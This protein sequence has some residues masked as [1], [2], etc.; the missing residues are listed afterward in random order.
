MKIPLTQGKFA[1]VDECDYEFLM[2]WTWCY[3]KGYAVRC[4]SNPARTIHMHR[5]I[6]ERMGFR[7]FAECDHANQDKLDNC[8]HNLRPA[9]RCQNQRNKNKL[10]NNTS[11]YIGVYWNKQQS[12]WMAYIRI[13]GKL[14]HLGY[15]DDKEDAA[16][17][18]DMAAIVHHGEFAQLNFPCSDYLIEFDQNLEPIA[19]K[20][21]T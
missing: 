21:R 8:R 13:D 3:H 6:L 16:R 17:A 18:R 11:G 19:V 12:K 14:K 15:F 5:V 7:D 20:V 9:T 2:Q 1:L 4:T 10:R